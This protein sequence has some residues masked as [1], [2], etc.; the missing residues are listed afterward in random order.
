MSHFTVTVV[1]K[2]EPSNEVLTEALQPFHE[3][4]C[5]G[6]DDQYV[7]DVDET[8][9]HRKNYDA[10]VEKFFRDPDGKL[11]DPYDERFTAPAT[12]ADY[13]AARKPGAKHPVTYKSSDPNVYRFF[14]VLPGGW[15]EI[16][17]PVKQAVSFLKFVQDETDYDVI[18]AGDPHPKYGRI[19]VAPD[20]EVSAVIRRTNPNRKWDWWQLGGRWNGSLIAKP[21]ATGIHGELSWA[22][23]PGQNPRAF[24]ALRK[25]D[26]VFHEMIAREIARALARLED[27]LTGIQKRTGM[28]RPGV[29][30]AW[31]SNPNGVTSE[32]S[33]RTGVPSTE[34]D[35]EGYLRLRNSQF[36]TFA[37]LREGKW[38]E[39]G[40]MGWWACV[41]DEKDDWPAQYLSLLA[42]VPEDHWISIV[43][44]HI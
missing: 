24:D 37:F 1:T 33:W 21:G 19:V 43:D 18:R 7:V 41:A 34:P 39:E 35:P 26:A 42:D 14:R 2:D 44:C 3:Y 30:A 28:D 27:V 10:R 4:E 36:Y 12:E 23:R 38:A 40:E 20:G 9:E 15:S 16:E 31:K 11:Y 17:V 8:E 13:E 22:S 6:M 25:G 32:L 5:T 29:L